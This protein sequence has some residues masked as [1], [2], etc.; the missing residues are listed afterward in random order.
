MRT[1]PVVLRARR[2]RERQLVSQIERRVALRELDINWHMNQARYLQVMELGRVD[3][4]LR[5]GAEAQLRRQGVKTVVAEQRVVYRRELK[6]GT[7]YLIDTRA[8][9]VEGRLL[10]VQSALLVGDRVHALNDTMMIFI[11]AAG[12]LKPAEV[13]PVCE[14]LTTT[15]LAVEGWRVVTR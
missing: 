5:S 2:A 9:G 14:G 13:G 7:S 8:L 12:V 1:A 15:P 4:F 10:R 3:W 11:G 6:L